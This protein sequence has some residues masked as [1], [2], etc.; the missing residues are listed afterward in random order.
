MPSTLYEVHVN[1][2]A[3]ETGWDTLDE[4]IEAIAAKVVFDEGDNR[5]VADCLGLLEVSVH[6]DK[7][8]TTSYT[9]RNQVGLFIEGR[10][11]EIADEDDEADRRLEN[12]RRLWV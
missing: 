2:T 7:S 4:Y 5:L 1:G 3:Q 10:A 9:P 6:A 8:V 11:E 12:W